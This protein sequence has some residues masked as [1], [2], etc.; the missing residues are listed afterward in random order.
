MRRVVPITEQFLPFYAGSPRGLLGD[1]YTQTRPL[2]GLLSPAAAEVLDGQELFLRT[3]L[4][5]LHFTSA[6]IDF[7]CPRIS[8]RA[9]H[10]V[11]PAI[12]EL[13]GAIVL[14]RDPY[15]AGLTN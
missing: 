13:D 3:Q 4:L 12:Y 5:R 2:N 1:C 10:L 15:A 8:L 14:D 7:V 9:D 6:L 11:K